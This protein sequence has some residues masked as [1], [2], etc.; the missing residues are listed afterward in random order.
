MTQNIQKQIIE[1]IKNGKK[2]LILPSA[3]LD[4][5]S[6]GGAISMYLVLKKLKKEVTVIC[7]D[8][9]PDLLQ[10]LPNMKILGNKMNST[11]DFIITLDCKNIKLETIKTAK[12]DD[13]VNIIITPKEGYISE[14][15]L[16]FNKGKADYDLV[17][18]LDCA[19]LSQLGK[20]YE[21]NIELFHQIPVINIDH[22]ISNE[23]F[24]KLNYVDIMASSTTELLLPMIEELS[25]EENI[26]LIDE[27]VATLLL[28]GIITDTGSFQNAN[29]TPRSFAIS[30]Q[31]IAYG[32][33]QQEIIQHI[34]KT[35]QLSQLKLWGRVLSKIQTD[36]KYKIVWSA[37]SQQ[38]F[39]DTES[40]ED[41]T[42]DIIDE[43]MTNAPGAEIVLLMKEKEEG[44]VSVSCRTT[45]PSIDASKFAEY[46]GGGGHARAAGFRV[47]DMS[48]R[49]AEY[50]VIQYAK[51]FQQE[52]LGIVE[53]PKAEK[54]EKTKPMINVEELMQRAKEAQKATELMPKVETQETP[55]PTNSKRSPGRP[56]KANRAEAQT[57]KP[58]EPDHVE[59][60]PSLPTEESPISS[61][62][63]E[64]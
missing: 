2:I 35:K 28:T 50:K 40:S 13:K 56:K 34:Y 25:K 43:L 24:G 7:K 38:D 15:N 27:D 4:G 63:F 36:E 39:K 29:T 30:A 53:E 8:P 17:I 59:F 14:E 22:H 47:S 3:P 62:K 1:L 21:E 32:A 61:Y 23:H 57:V 54:I 18:T 44:Y 16:T 37:V 45:A 6:L 51:K 5:D 48:L 55:Q 41:Q 42:G 58:P 60:T 11:T 33:R 19:E 9:V 31:L 20:I 49:D 46:F 10:F 12:E 26:D 52:R 64:D